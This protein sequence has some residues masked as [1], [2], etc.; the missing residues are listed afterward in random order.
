MSN[1]VPD[2]F[3]A[4]TFVIYSFKSRVLIIFDVLGTKI[5]VAGFASGSLAT[6]FE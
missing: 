1:V 6:S 2:N 3:T 4:P 5:V